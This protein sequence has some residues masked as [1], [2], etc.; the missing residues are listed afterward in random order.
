MGKKI[1]NALAYVNALRN[2]YEDVHPTLEDVKRDIIE[3]CLKV[4]N[5]IPSLREALATGHIDG[6]SYTAA[7]V[8][9]C[10][11]FTGTLAYATGKG[12]VDW[13]DDPE[14][15]IDYGTDKIREQWF[16]SIK[17]GDTPENSEV[18]ALT[19]SWV[20]EAL[21]LSRLSDVFGV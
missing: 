4:P 10:R 7:W 20:D 9:N 12:W 11:C 5:E 17:P 15:P 18:C 2:R 6:G 19:L 13:R 16:L 1:E 3:T 14:R 21:D 8:S